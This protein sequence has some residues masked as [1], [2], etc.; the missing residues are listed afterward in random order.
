MAELYKGSA[1]L[2][3]GDADRLGSKAFRYFIPVYNFPEAF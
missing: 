3:C 1:I 2:L